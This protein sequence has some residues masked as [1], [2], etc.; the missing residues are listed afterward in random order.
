MSQLSKLVRASFPSLT[1]HTLVLARSFVGCVFWRTLQ[2]NGS[3]CNGTVALSCSYSHTQRHVNFGPLSS[4]LHGNKHILNW[5]SA[6]G[7]PLSLL[8]SS[9]IGAVCLV[10][11]FLNRSRCLLVCIM[12]GIVPGDIP[13]DCHEPFD[14]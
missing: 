11:F 6:L 12:I 7:K 3:A 1:A 8:S 13:T 4:V 9:N 14:V 2:K 10:L 5:T